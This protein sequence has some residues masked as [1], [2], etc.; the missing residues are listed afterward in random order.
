MNS[1]IIVGGGAAGLM[2][3]YELSKHKL[4]VTVLEGK[5]R[6][7]GRIHTITDNSFG[8]TIEAGAEFIHGDLPLTI[9]LL[10]NA[11]I[12]Y[13]AAND[14][15]FHL[16]KG[17]LKEQKGFAEHWDKL[18][19]QMR[20]LEDDMPLNDF[21]SKFFKDDRYAEL[22]SSVK[23]F[24]GGFDLAEISAAS[25]KALYKEWSKEMGNQ[26][27]IDGGYMQLINY[28]EA[29]CRENSCVIE[30]GC[31]VKKISWQLNEV[32]IISMCS[33]LFKGNKVAFTVPVSVLQS[34]TDDVNYIEFTPS[35]PEHISAAKNIGFGKVIKIIIGF[36]DDFWNREKKDAGFFL[37]NE[38]I[39]TWWT[40]SP[41]SNNILTGWAGG[42]KAIALQNETNEN[43]LHKALQSLAAAFNIN[44]SVVKQELRFCK[45][46]N[47]CADPGINGGYSFN[48]IESEKAKSFLR[49]PI[50]D[51]IFF[52]G[53]ALFNGTPGGTV[54]AA[55][56][57]GKKM[58]SQV[59]E[60]L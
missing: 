23:N 38:E 54:E 8:C 31:G 6:L 26:Y 30:T 35:I 28:L 24:A 29:I 34:T 40:Q 25:T 56:H 43:I 5:D 1:V 20:M 21:L 3:A 32:E 22:R 52:G 13:H 60:T 15:M 39:P 16:E 7:G 12:K 57:S 45:I 18:M 17:K 51:T 9:S 33:R 36:A 49:K 19:K 53:E 58:A 2:A 59:L 41:V 4:P 37:T 44:I 47:W 46:A 27:R 11:G 42:E 10:N 55:L 48:T 14:N 50:N